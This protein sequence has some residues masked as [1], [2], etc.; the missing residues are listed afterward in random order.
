MQTLNLYPA[1]LASDLFRGKWF[2][3]KRRRGEG[4]RINAMDKEN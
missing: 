3:G 1:R 2:T 4:M